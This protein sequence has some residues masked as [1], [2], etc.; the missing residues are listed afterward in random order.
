MSENPLSSCLQ[1]DALQAG[2]RVLLYIQGH[3]LHFMGHG[4]V[5]TIF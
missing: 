4:Y 1:M 3:D 5:Y 2:D